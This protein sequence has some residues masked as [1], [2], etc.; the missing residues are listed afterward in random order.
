M[1]KTME[2]LTDPTPK[3]VPPT[4]K[5]TGKQPNGRSMEVGTFRM[6]QESRVHLKSYAKRVNLAQGELLRRFVSRLPKQRQKLVPEIVVP[7]LPV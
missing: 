6:S 2:S 7:I 3:P 4:G 5:L 1:A